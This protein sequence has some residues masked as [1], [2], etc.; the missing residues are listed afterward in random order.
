[1]GELPN[2]QYGTGILNIYQAVTEAAF[3]GTFTGEITNGD[4]EKISGEILLPDLNQTIE[5]EDGSFTHKI[6]EG[7]H[8]VI[9]QSFGYVDFETTITI[10]KMIQLK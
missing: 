7:E 3:A 2:T 1:M 6:R 5:V 8:E 9:V 4:G 10:E